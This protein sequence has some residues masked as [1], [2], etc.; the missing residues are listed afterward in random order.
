MKILSE[1]IKIAMTI[2]L[3]TV[4]VFSSYIMY[5]SIGYAL[6][7]DTLTMF[8]VSIVLFG[9]IVSF[10]SNIWFIKNLIKG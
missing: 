8:I 4:L 2:L 10:G 6:W 5:I 1:F 7:Y 9:F 3:S